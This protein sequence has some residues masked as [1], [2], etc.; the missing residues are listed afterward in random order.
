[1]RAWVTVA[2]ARNNVKVGCKQI[3]QYQLYDYWENNS[4]VN[5]VI[6]RLKVCKDNMFIEHYYYKDKCLSALSK[7]TPATDYK[8]I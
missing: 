4:C 6:N 5:T 7:L 8:D 2:D 3:G 1:M